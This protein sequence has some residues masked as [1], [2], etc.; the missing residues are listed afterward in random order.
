MTTAPLERYRSS[1]LSNNVQVIKDVE[2][3]L[4]PAVFASL[5]LIGRPDRASVSIRNTKLF[6]CEN[7]ERLSVRFR[8]SSRQSDGFCDLRIEGGCLSSGE[9]NAIIAIRSS[10]PQ[11]EFTFAPI[12]VSR[13]CAAII[14]IR[15]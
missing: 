4:A 3:R 15:K 5:E 2:H 7:D 9:S 12:I 13:S 14:Y 8:Y 10:I 1:H 6:E 11:S